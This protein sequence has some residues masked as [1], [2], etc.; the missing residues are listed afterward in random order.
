MILYKKLPC[1][2]GHEYN[3][4]STNSG[5]CIYKTEKYPFICL[6]TKY[7]PAGHNPELENVLCPGCKLTHLELFEKNYICLLCNCVLSEARVLEM[8]G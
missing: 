4:H 3:G 6:C 7:D 1:V 5:V 2:C 8:V